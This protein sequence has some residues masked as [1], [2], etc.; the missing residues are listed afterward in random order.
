MSELNAYVSRLMKEDTM[1]RTDGK[2]DSIGKRVAY[3]VKRIRKIKGFTQLELADEMG[4][5]QPFIARIE[6]G[7]NNI[8][9]KKLE[10]L[11]HV[12]AMDPMVLL[13][14]IYEE[15]TPREVARIVVD[16]NFTILAAN[17]GAEIILKEKNEFLLGTPLRKGNAL[18]DSVTKAFETETNITDFPSVYRDNGMI[19]KKMTTVVLVYADNGEIIGADVSCRTHF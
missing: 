19:E 15:G 10:Q 12:F 6:S 18:Y 7:K 11:A 5:K 14:P 1:F 2:G 4:V 16:T 13:R 9:I 8:S 3:N 17:I